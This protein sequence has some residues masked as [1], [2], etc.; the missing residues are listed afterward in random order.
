MKTAK[1]KTV[2]NLY[3][4]AE[5]QTF[6]LKDANAKKSPDLAPLKIIE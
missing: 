4:R 1:I 3:Q 5:T 6:P 2:A